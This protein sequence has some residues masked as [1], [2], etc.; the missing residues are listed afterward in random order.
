M[1]TRLANT[2]MTSVKVRRTRICHT[3]MTMTTMQ[4]MTQNLLTM[5]PSLMTAITLHHMT[6][7]HPHQTNDAD[8][9]QVTNNHR[10]KNHE[11]PANAQIIIDDI[12]ISM[13]STHI[14]LIN[15]QMKCDCLFDD[16]LSKVN[17]RTRTNVSKWSSKRKWLVEWMIASLFDWYI[18]DVLSDISLYY[19]ALHISMCDC[20]TG[21]VDCCVELIEST[22][23][24][25]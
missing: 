11:L 8:L 3:V 16:W 6:L 5:M 15:M 12:Q 14:T 2:P 22:K 1:R 7:H 10:I 9:Q 23:S 19:T 24:I 18:D 13:Y 17:W 4:L 25:G 21:L 20:L